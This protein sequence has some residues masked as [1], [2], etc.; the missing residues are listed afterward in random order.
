ML[1]QLRCAQKIC[2]RWGSSHINWNTDMRN[3]NT[4]ELG[5]AFP[6]QSHA[7]QG[8]VS[9]TFECL[10]RLALFFATLPATD[11]P[12]I[13]WELIPLRVPTPEVA[14]PILTLLLRRTRQGLCP[15]YCAVSTKCC[16]TKHSSHS[17]WT[18]VPNPGFSKRLPRYRVG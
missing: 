3:H 7:E 14:V 9:Y 1:I 18:S 12:E 10:T 13:E 5:A 11:K 8:I 2:T 15:S 16:L 4:G 17:K 6:A